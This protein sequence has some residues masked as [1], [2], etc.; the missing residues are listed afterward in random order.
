[1]RNRQVRLALGSTALVGLLALAAVASGFGGESSKKGA[2][3]MPQRAKAS[4]GAIDNF[5][6][7]VNRDFAAKTAKQTFRSPSTGPKAVAG[8][9][10]V[11]VPC[12]M[13]AEGC[14]RPARWAL[15]AAKRI[16]WDAQIIDPAGDPSKMSDAVRRAIQLGADGLVL[17]AID[18][19][20][21]LAALKEARKANIAVT[22]FFCAAAPGI[23]DHVI[24][25][26]ASFV[27]DGYTL[28]QAAYKL[29]G[30]DVRAVMMIDREF[31]LLGFRLRGTEKFVSD[32]KA[33]GGKCDILDRQN[34]LITQLATRVPQLAAS[35]A[36][37]NSTFNILWADYDA[38]LNFMIQ[39][40]QQAGLLRGSRFAVS[41]DANVANLDR[42]RTNK[43]Q[44]ATIGLPM[45]W[46]GYAQID[47]LN[48]IFAG[49]RAVDSGVHSKL[50]VKQNVPRAGAWDG[51]RDVRLAYR[52]IWGR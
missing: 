16:G 52:K 14:A 51:D 7:K 43:F 6:A 27:T 45:R 20:V 42:I 44:K 34:F 33:A 37:K 1:M 49:G 8:K 50:L 9:S 35:L 46:I 41:F 23:Y 3:V 2:G 18:A 39:G 26:P 28:G 11:I 13:A 21:I 29:S 4:A 47:D 10:I 24:P 36:R 12:A 15:E 32:C 38:G 17:E 31:E 30:G 40:L 48:R 25:A 19:K 22:C 5:N